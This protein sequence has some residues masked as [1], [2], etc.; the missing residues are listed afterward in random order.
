M[1]TDDSTPEQGRSHR[2]SVWLAGLLGLL[3]IYGLSPVPLWVL[4]FRWFPESFE[5][6]QPIF[7][8]FYAPLLWLDDHNSAV[9]AFYDW[10]GRLFGW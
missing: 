3:L 9:K 6:W 5:T 2:G 10:Y 8:G 7:E 1:D 4:L